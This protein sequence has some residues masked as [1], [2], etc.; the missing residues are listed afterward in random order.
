[1]STLPGSVPISYNHHTLYFHL[2]EGNVM[3]DSGPAPVFDQP[4]GSQEFLEFRRK[5]CDSE[6]LS[7][8]MERLLEP[9]R[10][11]RRLSVVVQNG[12]V[13]KSVY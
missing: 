10:F 13:L 12:R 4:V 2:S 5:M 7:A 9:I 3:C 6:M 1:M 11:T 8:T